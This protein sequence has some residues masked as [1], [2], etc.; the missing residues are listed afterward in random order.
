M[1]ENNI[2]IWIVIFTARNEVGA[3][4]I[5]TGVCHSVNRGCACSWGVSAPGGSGPGG[6]SAPGGCA[7]WR[8]PGTAIAAGGMHP[9]GMHSCILWF[10]EVTDI[11]DCEM[12]SRHIS[13][14]H[15]E[16]NWSS[17]YDL[18]TFCCYAHLLKRK[19]QTIICWSQSLLKLIALSKFI[20]SVLITTVVL[21]LQ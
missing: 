8:P 13:P 3:S 9:T 17:L 7:W 16:F 5:F 4:Y 19:K 10:Y 12:R 21:F 2:V 6:V 11:L 14:I 20:N 1:A 15:H 18:F